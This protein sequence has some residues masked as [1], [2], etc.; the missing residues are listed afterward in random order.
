[1]NWKRFSGLLGAVLLFVIQSALAQTTANLTGTV[2]SDN[3]AIPGVTVTVTSPNLQGTRTAVTDANGNYNFATLPPG[4]YSVKFEMEGM[5]TVT[6]TAR[7]SLSGT[8]RVDAKLAVTRVSESMTVTAAAPAVVETTEIQTNLPQNLVEKLPLSRTLIG[9]VD[10][11]PGTTRTGPGNATTISG[12]PSFE[13]TFYVDGSVINEVLRGQPNNLFIEDALQ[14]TTVQT[15][16]ISAE[17][18]RF[19]GGVVSAISKS[20]GNE[21]SGSLR[22]TLTNPTWTAQTPLKEPRPDS[23]LFN[24]YE[25]TAGGRIIRDR[26]WFF[27]AGRYRKRDQQQALFR[28]PQITYPFSDTEKRLEGKLTAQVT[29]KHSLVGSYIDVKDSQINNCFGNCYETTALDS[30][31]KLPNSFATLN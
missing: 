13:N 10:V 26:L 29:P 3:A 2:T 20:G 11:A 21:F 23:K 18:G 25:G 30:P 15:G 22:D 17:F 14:E 24:V 31:R 6:H 5:Q 7:V 16:A 9:T 1:M 8:A 12:A 19:T 4:D 28:Q 27:A